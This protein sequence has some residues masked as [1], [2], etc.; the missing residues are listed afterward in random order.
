MEFLFFKKLEHSV[1]KIVLTIE[2]LGNMSRD[3]AEYF[4]VASHQDN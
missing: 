2:K 1:I 3:E 4:A